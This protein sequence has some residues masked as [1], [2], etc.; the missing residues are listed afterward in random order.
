[1]PKVDVQVTVSDDIRLNGA[2]ALRLRMNNTTVEL[3][4]LG[5]QGGERKVLTFSRPNWRTAVAKMAEL[6]EQMAGL[7]DSAMR[8]ASR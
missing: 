7:V 6:D 4:E 3:I 1:M 2:P 5:P 8:A